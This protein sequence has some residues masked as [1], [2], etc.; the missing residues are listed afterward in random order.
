[1]QNDLDIEFCA[2][3]RAFKNKQALQDVSFLAKTGRITGFVGRNGAGKTTALRIL[4]GLTS[5]DRGHATIGGH[6]REEL[7]WGYLGHLLDAGF[8]PNRSGIDHLRIAGALIGLGNRASQDALES[9]GLSEVGKKPVKSYSVGMRQRLGLATALLGEP[10]V[11]VLDE[12]TNGLDPDGVLW[13]REQ[14]R[15]RSLSGVTVLLSSH[16]LSEL[17]QV[18]DDLVVLDQ[19]VL[20][21]GDRDQALSAT[22]EGTLEGLYKSLRVQAVA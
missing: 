20:W 4:L 9:V 19:T 10:R 16:L 18:V 5:S 13:L 2:V 8:H 22:P 12:P 17:E 15:A 3:S 11:L 14:L 7:P 1:M 6:T 21:Q